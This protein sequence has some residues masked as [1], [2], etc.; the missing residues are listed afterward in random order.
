MIKLHLPSTRT[1]FPFTL[2]SKKAISIWVITC[3][4]HVLFVLWIIYSFNHITTFQSDSSSNNG[5][6]IQVKFL[7]T[8]V[9]S[10]AI[11]VSNN[12]EVKEQKT[13][14]AKPV[15]KIITTEI[16]QKKISY[17]QNTP[18][19]ER[20]N[21]NLKVVEKGPKKLNEQVE[22]PSSTSPKKE[23]LTKQEVDIP[24]LS[25]TAKNFYVSNNTSHSSQ[26][27]K[28][29]SSESLEKSKTTS[30]ALKAL[31]RRLNY[32]TRARSLGVEGRVRVQFDIT[33]NGTVSNIRVVSE[34]PVGV[35]TDS[36]VKD[37]ARWR[38]QTTGEVKNQIVNIVFKL[39]GRVVLDN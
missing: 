31:N 38:Y 13:Q 19:V 37:M 17:H 16:S 28:S 1:A 25:T 33:S 6:P 30:V 11:P 27:Q 5:S 34:N 23:S 35:F 39:D 22:V 36:V 4:L 7:R 24:T 14:I 26:Q 20:I 12:V 10:T 2:S 18:K 9:N 15:S 32:P 29:S 8:V 21:E 3:I